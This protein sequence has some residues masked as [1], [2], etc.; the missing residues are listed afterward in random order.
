MSS[1]KVEIFYT[2]D[3]EYILIYYSN[4]VKFILNGMTLIEI[5][6]RVVEVMHSISWPDRV[7]GPRRI[8]IS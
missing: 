6:C 3:T 5:D 1:P 2:T 4:D 8:D 7:T